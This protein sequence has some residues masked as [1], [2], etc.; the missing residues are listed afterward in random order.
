MRSPQRGGGT[1]ATGSG[2][3]R[4]IIQGF[5]YQRSDV[6]DGGFLTAFPQFGA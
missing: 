5:A 6:K 2:P 4:A 1:G 3:Y